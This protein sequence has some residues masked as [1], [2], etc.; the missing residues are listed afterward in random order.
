MKHD[1]PVD[2][3]IG[4]VETY[5]DPRGQKGDYEGIVHFVDTRMTRLQKDLAGLAQYFE[6]RAPWDGRF[7]RQ[8]F[9]IP[10]AKCRRSAST[11]R[12]RRRSGSATATRAC[13]W[14][15]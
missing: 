8:G 9:N 11:C 7:K 6:D 10:I 5:K 1:S 15:T 14:S 2:A 4:F 13:R 12:T 3:V